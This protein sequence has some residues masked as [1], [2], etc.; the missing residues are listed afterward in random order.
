MTRP[1]NDNLLNALKA[2]PIPAAFFIKQRSLSQ[3]LSGHPALSHI[4]Y[5]LSGFHSI[6]AACKS[7]LVA[8]NPNSELDQNLL[9][10]D[11]L[12]CSLLMHR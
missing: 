1:P 8:E 7:W 4:H 6:P 3:W 11:S 10:V 2:Q 9:Q 12:S 5:S